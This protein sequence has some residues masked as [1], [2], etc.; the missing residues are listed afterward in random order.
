MKNKTKKKI[1]IGSVAA[2]AVAAAALVSAAVASTA[3]TS[4]PSTETD[5]SIEAAIGSFIVE[6]DADGSNIR[7]EDELKPQINEIITDIKARCGGDWSVYVYVPSTG[8]SLSINNKKMQAAS[9]IKLYIMGAVYDE[10]DALAKHYEGTDVPEL[11]ESMITVS[12][13][14]AADTLVAM[15][16]RGDYAAG[17]KKVNDFCKKYGFADTTMDRLMSD[18]NLFSDNYT[19]VEDSGKFLAMALNAELP[20]SKDMIN[21]LKAQTRKVKIPDGLPENVLCANKTG[22]LDDVQNDSAIVFASKPYVLCVMADG[23][24]DY[25][26][27]IDAIADIST[28]TYNYV[29]PKLTNE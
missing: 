22:E 7:F 19:T 18:D 15:L 26:P 20:H 16:G 3:G 2:L 23:V 6:A 5:G 21:Y 24:G 9:V 28:V 27:P 4:A 29:A 25:Q 10:Y 1:V 14:E 17:R 12:D 8:D 13:N 11:I